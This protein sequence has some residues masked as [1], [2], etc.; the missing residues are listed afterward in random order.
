MKKKPPLQQIT[1]TVA[2]HHCEASFRIWPRRW[3]QWRGGTCDLLWCRMTQIEK[4]D[5]RQV[6]FFFDGRKAWFR[7]ASEL[8]PGQWRD[9]E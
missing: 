4:E 8:P 6:C 2:G 1:A 7:D 5:D 3:W 9:V